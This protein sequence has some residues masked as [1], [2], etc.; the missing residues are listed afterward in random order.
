MSAAGRL[1][2]AAAATALVGAVSFVAP[3]AGAQ[4]TGGCTATVAGQ[5]AD[6]AHNARNA[7]TVGADETIVVAGTAPGP[8]TGY[9]VFMTFG[10]AR[11]QV[12]DGEVT[13]GGNTWT[14]TVDVAD[15]ATY[16]VGL[17]RIEGETT[18]TPC[19]GWAYVKVTGKF[20]LFTVAGAVGGLLTLGGAAGMAL[21]WPRKPKT[22]WTGG[23]S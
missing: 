22:T 3:P 9:K 7:I 14:S 2:R 16:G 1:A 5:D 17:Y 21:S 11:V 10:P 4:V 19:T 6:G 12:A 23:A 8:I 20:P 13:D 18:G 15:Y